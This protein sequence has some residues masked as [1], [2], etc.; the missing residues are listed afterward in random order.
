MKVHIKLI[1]VEGLNLKEASIK[2]AMN[3]KSNP[4]FK[5]IYEKE[6]A[7]VNAARI[8]LTEQKDEA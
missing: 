4:A 1:I 3:T 6:Q 5:A 7:D 2:R 8:W